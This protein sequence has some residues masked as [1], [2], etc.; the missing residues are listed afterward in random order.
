VYP[1]EFQTAH[2]WAAAGG[3]VLLCG[4]ILFV[5]NMINSRRQP[6]T[7]NPWLSNGPE[8]TPGA[9]KV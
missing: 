2:H 4:V 9:E 3:V 1:A 5:F 7:P 8:W 6:A